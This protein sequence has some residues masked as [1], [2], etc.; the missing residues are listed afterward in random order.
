[1]QP[2]A[3]S[4]AR[5]PDSPLPRPRHADAGSRA[6][7]YATP[8]GLRSL[9]E[10]IVADLARQ[11]VPAHADDILITTGSQQGIDLVA[12]ALIAPGDTFLV[13]AATYAGAINVFSLAGA[14]LVPG[15]FR[16]R[17][18]RHGGARAPHARRRQGAL[19]DAQLQQPDRSRDLQRS[20]AQELVDWSQ[21]AGVPLIEDDYGSDLV[22]RRDHRRR[23]R[24]ARSAAT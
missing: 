6:L 15:S 14:R 20:A 19:L 7:G 8:E 10:L 3:G 24:S 18:A 11:G 5:S 12:R 4:S 9:R 1:M 2:S 17:G 23:R 21:R 13:D 16:R 22:A